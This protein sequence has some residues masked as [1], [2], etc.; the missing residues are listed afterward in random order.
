MQNRVYSCISIYELL[1]FPC[2]QLWTYL[3]HRVHAPHFF[4][5]LLTAKFLQGIVYNSQ[6]SLDWA[7]QYNLTQLL[8]SSLKSFLHCSRDISLWLDSSVSCSLLLTF[9][10]WFL[11]AF[12]AL[13]PVL[14]S[15]C[16]HSLGNL[17]FNDSYVPEWL[18]KVIS[19]T[20]LDPKLRKSSTYLTAPLGCLITISDLQC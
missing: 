3:P 9:L 4:A 7:H 13:Q 12:P 20:D 18:P 5:P 15:V 11:M 19:S 17:G 6:S 2:E 14:F 10:C 16:T 8:I 1:Y